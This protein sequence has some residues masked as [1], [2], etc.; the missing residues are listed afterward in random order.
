M[1]LGLSHKVSL[2][3]DVLIQ[4]LSGESV[5]LNID[6]EQYFGLDE[7]GS[8]MLSVLTESDSIQAA[9]DILLQE[10][11]VEPAKLEQDLLELIEK[12]VKHGLV[13]VTQA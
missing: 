4:E 5:L 9:N 8:R 11:E 2:A 1:K 3:E 7:V 12:C 10:Y 6:S 13:K